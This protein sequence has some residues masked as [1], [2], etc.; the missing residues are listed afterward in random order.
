MV[1]ISHKG[2][3]KYDPNKDYPLGKI[4]G[5]ILHKEAKFLSKRHGM[6]CCSTGR[7]MLEKLDHLSWSFEYPKKLS[8]DEGR[9]LLIDCIHQVIQHVNA[10]PK[11]K[12]YFLNS[13][14]NERNV[15]I[16]IFCHDKEPIIYPDIDVFSFYMKKFIME[17][18]PLRQNSILILP[19]MMN[20]IKTQLLF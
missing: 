8:K 20:P 3:F 11:A 12:P 16:S 17:H 13:E 10:L 7:S 4:T 1:L 9:A 5:N 15:E 2:P 6:S 19:T 18:I 14:F